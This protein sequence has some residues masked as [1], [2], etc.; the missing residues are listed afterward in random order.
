VKAFLVTTIALTLSALLCST[1][2]AQRGSS[3]EVKDPAGF[4][5]LQGEPL[6]SGPQPGEK[7]PPFAATGVGGTIDGKEFDPAA[8]AGDKPQ[9]L[10]FQDDSRVGLRGLYGLK[11]SL[12]RIANES[13]EGLRL[14][15]VFLSDDASS[16]LER[17]ARLASED[18]LIGVSKDGRDGPGA[19]G[20]N[21]NV[22]QTIIIAKD[23]KVLYNFPFAQP[24]LY[25]DPYVLGAIAEVLGEDRETLAKW[26]IEGQREAQQMREEQRMRNDDSRREEIIKR[27]DKDGDGTLNE[28][29]GMAARSALQSRE[30]YVRAGEQP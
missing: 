29:E 8:L 22:A 21:R 14:A 7:L 20:L 13:D 12:S 16:I 4:A 5:K 11:N 30:E 24:L 28:E 6:F 23:G 25:P 10:V 27:F 19:Y 3:V 15:A 26:L 1:G 9:V 17:V 2:S 18:F